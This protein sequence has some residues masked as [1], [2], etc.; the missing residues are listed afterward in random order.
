MA[1]M[2]M[3]E[4]FN[5]VLGIIDFSVVELDEQI[6]GYMKNLLNDRNQAK[7]SKNF[8]LADQIRD[9]LLEK[10]YKIIDGREGSVLERV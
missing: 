5:E 3:F 6:D 2:D 8:E 4:N 7:I 9:E 1:I 10:G